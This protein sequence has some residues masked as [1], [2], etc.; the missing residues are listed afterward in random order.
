MDNILLMQVQKVSQVK[1]RAL[2][3]L[4]EHLDLEEKLA[5]QDLKVG[6]TTV[7]TVI[8]TVTVKKV[9]DFFHHVAGNR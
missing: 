7:F 3:D 4:L 6:N 9:T 5:E 2:L 8:Y 1:V